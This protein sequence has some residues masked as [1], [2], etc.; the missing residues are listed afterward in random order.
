MKF[1]VCT[2]VQLDKKSISCITYCTWTWKPQKFAVHTVEQLEY[3]EI[4]HW[5]FRKA[6]ETLQGFPESTVPQEQ[7]SRAFECSSPILCFLMGFELCNDSIN[8]ELRI[9]NEKGIGSGI[10]DHL[11]NIKELSTYVVMELNH[12]QQRP[13]KCLNTGSL[14]A[15]TTNLPGETIWRLEHVRFVLRFLP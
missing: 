4:L 8:G 1:A 6:R 7:Y 13:P 2:V 5:F 10:I 11:T 12:T 15:H 3:L 14:L 9:D